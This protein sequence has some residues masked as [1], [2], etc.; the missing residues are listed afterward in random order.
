MNDIDFRFLDLIPGLDE[1]TNIAERA[2]ARSGVTTL[3]MFWRQLPGVPARA[4]PVRRMVSEELAGPH[5][6]QGNQALDAVRES[7]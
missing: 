7:G 2:F 5:P 6:P 1:I 3:Q 4:G